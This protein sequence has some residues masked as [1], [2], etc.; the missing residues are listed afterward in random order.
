METTTKITL[1]AEKDTTSENLKTTANMIIRCATDLISVAITN[2]LK[3]ITQSL[4][5]LVRK[6]IMLSTKETTRE[7]VKEIQSIFIS[8]LKNIIIELTPEDWGYDFILLS[9]EEEKDII[10]SIIN[11]QEVIIALDKSAIGY[12][13]LTAD[14]WEFKFTLLEERETDLLTGEL[15][16]NRKIVEVEK[17]VQLPPPEYKINLK[18]WYYLYGGKEQILNVTNDET[19]K[20]YDCYIG[21]DGKIYPYSPDDSNPTKLFGWNF[22]DETLDELYEFLEK[23]GLTVSFDDSQD[24][25]EIES[26]VF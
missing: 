14:F 15:V 22:T 2:G 26:E 1:R 4:E 19:V 25:I 11:K 17:E 9:H 21:K 20:K 10:L 6:S 24:F 23:D 18:D 8:L 13:S 16:D 5:I 3:S 7:D 12:C